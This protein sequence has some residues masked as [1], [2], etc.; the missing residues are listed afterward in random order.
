MR[1]SDAMT[2]RDCYQMA[3]SRLSVP[4]VSMPELEARELVS[5]ALQC[6]LRRLPQSQTISPEEQTRLEALLKRR[7]QG[8]PLAYLLGEWDFYGITLRVTPDVLIPRSDTERLC[9]LAIERARAR[10]TPRVL[11]LCSGSGC[12]GLALLHEVPKAVGLGVDLS[13][14][15]VQL[16][17]ANAEQLGLAPRYRCIE[18]NALTVPP[19]EYQAAFD[20]MV[21]NPPYITEPEMRGLD[22]SVGAY[23]PH[24]ALYGGTDGLDFYRAIMQGWAQAVRPTGD[25]FFECGWTQ[26]QAV[27][28]IC[29]T[30]GW[31]NTT[32]ETDYAGV[33]R[34]IHTVRPD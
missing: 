9:E 16:A 32:I 21:C 23:E 33:P 6:D 11:D 13:P 31:H 20:V 3:C 26:G 30:A 1:G 25:I 12:I 2:I 29:I 10:Q 8:E 27:A 19:E 5:C 34:I 17:Q 24:L 15:A 4:E 28:E 14:K 7:L 22:V 18:G